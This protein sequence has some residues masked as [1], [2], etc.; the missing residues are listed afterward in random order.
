MKVIVPLV[1]TSL[2]LLVI[3]G[4]AKADVAWSNGSVTGVGSNCD[5]T[6]NACPGGDQG[7]TIFDNFDLSNDETVIAVS[8][9][10]D[11]SVGTPAD[12][13]STN[14]SLWAVDPLGPFNFLGPVAMGN[15]VATLTTNDLSATTYTFTVTGLA[16]DLIPGT[17]WL[18]TENVLAGDG[19]VTLDVMSN[20]TAVP[21][22]EEQSDD[23]DYGFTYGSGNTAFEIQN[24]PEPGS[25]WLVALAGLAF[26]VKSRIRPDLKPQIELSPALV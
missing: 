6:G 25:L 22:Y 2:A 23:K 8:Y 13:Q 18:G 17:Y 14:W 19:A 1:I 21:G 9:V 26:F 12:Y 11:F 20:G 15:A 4:T 3:Q 16:V 7:W 10:S 24:N 5:F